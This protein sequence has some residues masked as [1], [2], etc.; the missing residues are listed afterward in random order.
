MADDVIYPREEVLH[1]G[2]LPI[3]VL[4]PQ[5][6]SVVS[7]AACHQRVLKAAVKDANGESTP[8]RCWK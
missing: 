1:Y 8:G 5:L 6:D 4:L 3:N 2:L 7:L